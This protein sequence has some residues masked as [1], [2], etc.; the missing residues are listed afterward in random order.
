M[1]DMEV[2]SACLWCYKAR[3]SVICC[4]SHEAVFMFNMDVYYGVWGVFIWI[5][6]EL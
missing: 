4:D 2:K 1:D 5:L 3:V 6:K